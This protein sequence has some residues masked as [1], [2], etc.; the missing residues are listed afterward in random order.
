MA[1]GGGPAGRSANHDTSTLARARSQKKR[2]ASTSVGHGR[3]TNVHGAVGNGKTVTTRTA[4]RTPPTTMVGETDP[5]SSTQ[6]M[7]RPT[8]I[9]T[10]PLTATPEDGGDVGRALEQARRR[11]GR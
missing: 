3:M 1:L 11:P 2:P 4:A 6:M 9:G 5:H 8:T 10:G 7:V